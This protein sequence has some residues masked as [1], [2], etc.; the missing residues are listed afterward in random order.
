MAQREGGRLVRG[1]GLVSATALVAGNMIG[2]GI[3]VVPGSLADLAGPASLLAWLGAAAAYFCLVAVFADLGAAYPVSGGPQTFVRRA[4]GELAGFEASY[5]YWLSA[6]I[7]NAAFATGFVGYLKVFVP[8]LGSGWSAFFAAQAVLW[9]FTLVNLRGVQAGGRVQVVT[10]VLKILPLFV[11]CAALLSRGSTANLEPLAPRGYAPLWP[12]L[13]LIA[14]LFLGAESV[15]V[16]AEEI[17]GAG[18]TIRRAAFTG[19]SIAVAVYLL[20]AVSLAL[21]LPASAVGGTE[22][23]LATAGSLVLGP[24]GERLMTLAAL[25]SIAG[26]LNGWLLVAGRMP[27][28]A[29]REGL[30]PA[31]LARLDPHTGAPAAALLLSSGLSSTLVLLYFSQTLL[32]AYNFI[33]MASTATALVAIAGCCLA[34]IV[35]IEREPERF[36][37]TQ[38]RLGPAIAVAG[39]LAVGVLIVGSGLLVLGLTAAIMAL[40]LPYYLWLRLRPAAP[41]TP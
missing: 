34:E 19:F 33:A 27:F 9:G 40:L 3:Y 21:G 5:L 18:R 4:F 11:L 36:S 30:A 1:L 23:P 39:L 25:V 37:A 7:G 15:T 38:R 41:S 24:W 13:T 6:V 14:W 10:T 20:V 16:P 26:V 2:S 17:Q 22:S 28:A 31:W 29:A 12:C 8:S 35:L 32:E